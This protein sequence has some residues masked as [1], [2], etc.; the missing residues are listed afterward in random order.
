MNN[1]DFR[2]IKPQKR[3]T[4]TDELCYAIPCKVIK[5]GE[6]LYKNTFSITFER[7]DFK[8][9]EIVITNG[10]TYRKSL[11]IFEKE[12]IPFLTTCNVIK[13]GFKPKFV[14][15]GKF[16]VGLLESWFYPDDMLDE[17]ETIQVFKNNY[18]EFNEWL[19][20]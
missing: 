15:Y 13:G 10:H 20:I 12:N 9:G 18:K 8:T 3:K 6:C 1:V 2:I 11:P 5:I 14:V 7:V 16:N 19:G 4:L 17:K